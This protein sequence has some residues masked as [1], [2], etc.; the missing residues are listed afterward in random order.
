VRDSGTKFIL[1]DETLLKRGI[2][3]EIYQLLPKLTIK[4]AQNSFYAF[5]MLY[6][7]LIEDSVSSRWCGKLL[8][9]F[10]KALKKHDALWHRSNRQAE[11]KLA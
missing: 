7:V 3:K 9:S 8:K 10:L 11:E 4:K 5:L 2:T 1:I 6:N